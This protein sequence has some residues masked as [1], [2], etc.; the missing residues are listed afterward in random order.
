MSET[1][2]SYSREVVPMFIALNTAKQI[3]KEGLADDKTVQDKLAEIKVLQE[4]IK[5]YVAGKEEELLRE[6]KD[7]ETDIKL[8]C[9][10]AARGTAFKAADLKG[11]FQARAKQSVEKV[12]DKGQLFEELDK[13]LA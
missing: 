2:I 8:A 10:G 13:E 9:K 3:L 11:F 4:E 7:L 1:L 6:I 5:D 12:V